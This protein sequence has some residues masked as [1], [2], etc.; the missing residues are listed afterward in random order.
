MGDD[1]MK[2]L[3]AFGAGGGGKRVELS[4]RPLPSRST[5][6]VVDRIWGIRRRRVC[7]YDSMYEFTKVWTRVSGR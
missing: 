5:R 3:N 1:R 2:S 4:S 6:R 7:S